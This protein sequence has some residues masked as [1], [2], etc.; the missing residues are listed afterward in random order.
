VPDADV[1]L[2]VAVTKV[3]GEVMKKLT[4]RSN[5]LAGLLAR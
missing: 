5:D 4:R 1:G 2:F 3:D